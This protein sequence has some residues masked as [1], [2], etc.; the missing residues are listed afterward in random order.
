MVNAAVYEALRGRLR[1]RRKMWANKA[2]GCRMRPGKGL[3]MYCANCG[4]E[5]PEGSKVCPSCKAP[6]VGA[7]GAACAG[8]HDSFEYARTTV[9]SDLATVAT[10]CYECLGF[11]LTGTKDSAAGDT[12]V[13]S[14]RRS[15][16]VRGKAQLAKLQ[17]TADDLLARIAAL[18]AEKTR[19]AG[20]LSI[21]V[22]VISALVLGVGM[23]CTMVWTQLM[24]LGIIVGIAGIA[25]CVA[26]WLLYR[27]TVRKDSARVAPRI[28]AAYDSIATVCE[29]AQAVLGAAA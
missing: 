8:R 5:L 28:E 15:R 17:R 1:N 21:A 4:N 9:K 11:E 27:A 13:L 16:K 3:S 6:V 25:G 19:R 22:G 29:E 23:C 18:E 26:A 20:M 10:D 2:R 14:F 7:P 12:T 24:A